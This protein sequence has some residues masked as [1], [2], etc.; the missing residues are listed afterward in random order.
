[1]ASGLR[2]WHYHCCGAGSIPGPG[3]STRQ[4]G[5]QNKNK[6]KQENQQNKTKKIPQKTHQN[7]KESSPVA[8][9]VKD[10]ALLLLWHKFHP[11]CHDQEWN[12]AKKKLHKA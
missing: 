11:L 5:S 6:N 1:M 7:P 10:P 8:Q 12:V 4:G 9:W 2:I 3:T